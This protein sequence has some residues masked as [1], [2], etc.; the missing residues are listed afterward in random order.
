M[1]AP[2][3]KIG[4]K[5]RVL[6]KKRLK[7]LDFE[8]QANAIKDMAYRYNVTRIGIDTTSAGKAVYDLVVKWFPTARAYHYSVPLKTAMVLKAKNVISAGRLEFEIDWR[9]MATAFMAIKPQFTSKGVTYTAD[10]AGG[11]GHA[12]IAWAVMHALFF[13]PMDSSE[14]PDGTSSMEIF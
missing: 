8:G 13:E 4:G 10:R 14:S 3:Q 7:G 11:V 2:P 6:E 9:D 12:D 5:F 1:V